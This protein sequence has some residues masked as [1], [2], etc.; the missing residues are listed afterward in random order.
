MCL[1]GFGW[2]QKAQVDY[3]NGKQWIAQI[4]D[5]ISQVIWAEEGQQGKNQPVVLVGNSLGG[6]AS[7]ATGALRP[8]L[9]R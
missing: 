4:S 3:G 2:S 6:Y 7:L 9:V 1:L 5:Y 8:D